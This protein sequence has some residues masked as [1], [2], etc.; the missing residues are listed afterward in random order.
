MN[1]FRE[2]T[3]LLVIGLFIVAGVAAFAA[4]VVGGW[5][6]LVWLT[7]ADWRTTNFSVPI[8]AIVTAVVCAVAAT[9]LL[10][11]GASRL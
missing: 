5:D 6:M 4:V 1:F 9:A 10:F 2:M 7:G 3:G 11:V 8:I